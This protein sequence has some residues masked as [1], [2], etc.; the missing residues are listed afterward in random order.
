MQSDIGR[1]FEGRL[2]ETTQLLKVIY[3][4]TLGA[5][6]DVAATIEGKELVFRKGQNTGRGF[7]RVI[8]MEVY[9]LIAF[10]KG[11]E[12]FDP[13]K[14]TQGPPGSQKT[15][16]IRDTIDFDIYVRGLLAQAYALEKDDPLPEDSK[17]G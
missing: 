13:R 3:D 9:V 6:K 16:L 14:R 7:L 12:L 4:V 11:Q 15:T 5:G 10:P 8:P 17:P 1:Y 2:F